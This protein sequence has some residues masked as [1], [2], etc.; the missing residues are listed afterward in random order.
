MA[1]NYNLYVDQGST[2]TVSINLTDSDNS[3]KDLT[4]HSARSQMRRSYYSVSNTQ[5]SANI[6]DA[7]NGVITLSLTDSQ[8][9]NLKAGRYVYDVELISPANVITRIIEGIVVIS[10]EATK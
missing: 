8:T 2:Y 1:I 7:A 9:S 6:T 4:N 10:P 3:A 5:F